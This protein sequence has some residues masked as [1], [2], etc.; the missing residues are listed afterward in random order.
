MSLLRLAL[1]AIAVLC[2]PLVGHAEDAEGC[3]DHPLFNRMPRTSLASC[4]TKY[5]RLE[6]ASAPGVTVTKEGTLTQLVYGYEPTEAAPDGPSFLQIVKNYEN[7]IAKKGGKRLMFDEENA[8]LSL[9]VQGKQVWLVFT[10]AGRVGTGEGGYRL[11]VLEEEEMKQEIQASDILAA[12]NEKGRIA[13][14]VSFETGKATLLP[15]SERIVGEIVVLLK[16][17]AALELSIEGH[18][19]DRGTAAANQKLSEERAKAV[20]EAL[21][22]AGIARDRPAS[23]GHGQSKPLASNRTEEGRALNRRVEVVKR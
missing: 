14:Y 15:E 18:T 19:D 7:A 10:S 8:T 23:K 6:F 1:V 9:K 2:I 11:E 17:H 12:L 3:K 16:E 5:D 4:S 21:V 22:K 20:V 13:L